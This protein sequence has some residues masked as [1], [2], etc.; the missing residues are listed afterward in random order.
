MG[1][2]H[3]IGHTL[4]GTCNVPYGYTS[5]ITLPAVMRWN[6]SESRRAQGLI[7]EAMGRP[8]VEASE[9]LHKFIKDLGLPRTLEEVGIHTDQFEL[10]A[11]NTMHDHSIHT[12]P[13]KIRGPEEVIEILKI[14]A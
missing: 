11:K 13:R 6:E 9:V 1:A 3:A 4:G 12:N 14:V 5:C 7:A 2:S 10:I 8:G